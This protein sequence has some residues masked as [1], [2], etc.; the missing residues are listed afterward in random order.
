MENQVD[1]LRK[2]REEKTVAYN[3]FLRDYKKDKTKIVYGFVEGKDDIA[4][5]ATCI[6]NEIMQY[7]GEVCLIEC[8]GKNNLEYTYKKLIDNGNYSQQRVCFFRDRD[9]SDYFANDRYLFEKSNCYVTDKYSIEN[10][11][12][13][14]NLFKRMLNEVLGYNAKSLDEKETLIDKFN[15][16]KNKF[17]DEFKIVMAQIIY[18]KKIGN[19]FDLNK[20]KVKDLV[21]IK[22]IEISYKSERNKL[23]YVYKQAQVNESDCD[24][25][26]IQSIATHISENEQ[27]RNIIRGHYLADFFIHYCNAINKTKSQLSSK[28]DV[29]RILAPRAEKI[30]SL[31]EFIQ[32][33]Y[34]EYYKTI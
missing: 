31:C 11:L 25:K 13:T 28:L 22:G 32:K 33:T 1:E 7:G 19:K 5:Y 23:D 15:T 6:N 3:D 9:L 26:E 29:A 2:A 24:E 17:E 30:K 16:C 10:S 34:L 21:E 8:K 4:L 20:I 18:L 14:N 27:Y 12:I